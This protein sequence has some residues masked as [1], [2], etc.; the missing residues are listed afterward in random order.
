MLIFLHFAE[1]QTTTYLTNTDIYNKILMYNLEHSLINSISYDVLAIISNNELV[2][3]GRIS[4]KGDIAYI[5]IGLKPSF[6]GKGDLVY[7]L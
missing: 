1:T 4:L 7:E 3:S 6:C 5:G 2:A